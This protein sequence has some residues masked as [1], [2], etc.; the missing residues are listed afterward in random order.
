MQRQ[1]EEQLRLQLMAIIVHSAGYPLWWSGEGIPVLT[2]DLGDWLAL[3]SILV[4]GYSPI[5][6]QDKRNL[7]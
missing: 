4:V 6:T 1:M 2:Y 3:S 5:Q 7:K